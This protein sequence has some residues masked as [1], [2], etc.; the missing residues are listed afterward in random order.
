MTHSFFTYLFYYFIFWWKKVGFSSSFEQEELGERK[1][2]TTLADWTWETKKIFTASRRFSVFLYINIFGPL[3]AFRDGFYFLFF[4]SCCC[5]IKHFGGWSQ[6]F[7][8]SF[9]SLN[10]FL[11]YFMTFFFL[12]PFL[13]NQRPLRAAS[14]S[15]HTRL[16]ARA[17]VTAAAQEGSAPGAP[18]ADGQG[19]RP[20]AP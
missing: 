9:I 13:Y 1:D 19:G 7:P 11:F 5:F 20:P 8:F 15:C 4:S 14:H 12:L 10:T 6:L 2:S 18:S 16:P 3:S 17:T